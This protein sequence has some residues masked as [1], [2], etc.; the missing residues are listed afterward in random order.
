MEHV[1]Y[2]DPTGAEIDATLLEGGDDAESDGEA[3]SAGGLDALDHSEDEV[4]DTT[5]DA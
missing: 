3:D 4:S 2:V 5:E 1:T